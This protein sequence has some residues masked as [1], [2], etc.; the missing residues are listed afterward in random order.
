LVLVQ[1]VL[2]GVR[3]RSRRGAPPERMTKTRRGLLAHLVEGPRVEAFDR[4]VDGWA[5][6][7]RGN[8]VA[9]WIFYNLSAIGDHG[10]VWHIVGL[11]RAAIGA[12]TLVSAVE[13]SSA[14]GVEA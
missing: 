12:D 11:G 7:M 4:R 1:G 6:R 5:D 13:L 14:L 2:P 9:D 3:W 10:I 8:P